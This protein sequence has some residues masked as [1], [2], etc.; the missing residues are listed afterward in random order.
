MLLAASVDL[1]T[2]LCVMCGEGKALSVR[3][4]LVYWQETPSSSLKGNG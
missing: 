2:L 3:L 4:R 1:C